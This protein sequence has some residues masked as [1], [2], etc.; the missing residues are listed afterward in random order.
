[1]ALLLVRTFVV[2]IDLVAVTLLFD[3]VTFDD[4][5]N[6]DSDSVGYDLVTGN[7]QSVG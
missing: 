1:M 2:T 7:E 4:W 3:G 6:Q 5:W